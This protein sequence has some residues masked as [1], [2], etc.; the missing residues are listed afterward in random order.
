[1]YKIE[2]HIPRDGGMNEDITSPEVCGTETYN[3][4]DEAI[5]AA[6]GLESD[7]EDMDLD[8]DTIYTVHDKDG[9]QVWSA[10]D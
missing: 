3:T 4:L 8:P 2:A 6:I 1:M 10:A 9:K 7:L 5:M